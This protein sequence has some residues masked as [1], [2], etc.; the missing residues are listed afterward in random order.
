G[1]LVL[2]NPSDCEQEFSFD[3]AAVFE[4]PL[5]APLRYTLSSPKGDTLPAEA[6]A[7]TATTLRLKPFGVLVIEAT[8]VA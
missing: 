2:R 1:I 7:G 8:P 4:L 6:L 3:P 5:G